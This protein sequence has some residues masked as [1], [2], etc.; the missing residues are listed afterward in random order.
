MRVFVALNDQEVALL[1]PEAYVDG[2][3]ASVYRL[4]SLPFD[5]GDAAAASTFLEGCKVEFSDTANT[6]WWRLNRAFSVAGVGTL[7]REQVTTTWIEMI[8]NGVPFSVACHRQQSLQ[9]PW[10]SVSEKVTL[11]YIGRCDFS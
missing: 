11:M 6:Q 8:Q 10:L 4:Y 2:D 1:K 9:V 3:E 7:G 5:V